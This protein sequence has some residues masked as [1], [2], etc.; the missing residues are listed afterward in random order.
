[1]CRRVPYNV[2]YV[3]AALRSSAA[4]SRAAQ[5]SSKVLFAHALCRRTW[6][7]AGVAIVLAL[8]DRAAAFDEF[9]A[10]LFAEELVLFDD[11]LAA[12]EHDRGLAFD[13]ASLVRVVVDAHVVSLRGDRRR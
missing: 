11:D 6:S 8:Q 3:P 2:P 10:S 12:R 9:A 4:G 7:R 1:M 13:P 5:N